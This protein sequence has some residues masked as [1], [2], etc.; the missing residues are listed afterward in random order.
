M[1]DFLLK[2][3]R[4]QKIS[5]LAM[6][7]ILIGLFVWIIFGSPVATYLSTNFNEDLVKVTIDQFSTFFFPI[8]ASPAGRPTTRPGW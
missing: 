2:L 1:K 5:I 6:A 7:D 8:S 3:P 4:A